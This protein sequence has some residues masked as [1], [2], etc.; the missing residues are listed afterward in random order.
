MLERDGQTEALWL[1]EG[2]SHI[3]E[4]LNGFDDGNEIRTAAIAGAWPVEAWSAA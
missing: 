3:A 4:D 1:N 2:L